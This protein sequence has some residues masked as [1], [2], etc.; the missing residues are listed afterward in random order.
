MHNEDRGNFIISAIVFSK[1]DLNNQIKD[2]LSK[3][4]FDPNCF[5][6]KS[7]HSISKYPKLIGVRN[8]LIFLIH[9]CQFGL[10][11][12]PYSFRNEIGIESLKGLIQFIDN[13]QVND[14]KDVYIDEGILRYKNLELFKIELNK[15]NTHIP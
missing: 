2:I 4:G 6:Y 13:N 1:N 11:F 14:K 7:G 8:E 12:L 10:V 3:N 15:K 5:E 9:N